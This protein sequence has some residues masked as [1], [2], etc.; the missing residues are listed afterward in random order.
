MFRRKTKKI[1]VLCILI[2]SV[3]INF[4]CATIKKPANPVDPYETM[5]RKMFKFNSIFDNII[6][7]PIAVTYQTIIPRPL[8][9]GIS[10]FFS[11]LNE[12]TT[13]SNDFLQGNIKNMFA[14]SW[15]L[16]FNSTIGIGGLFD[17]ATSLGLPQRKN[18]FGLTLAKWGVRNSPYIVSPFFGPLTARD[19]FGAL[20]DYNLLSPWPYIEPQTFRYSL[21]GTYFINK[22]AK[23]LAADKFIQ[24]AFDPYIFVR[25]AYL[26]YRQ[27]QIDNMLGKTTEE[28]PKTYLS[29]EIDKTQSKTLE[30]KPLVM[31]LD[32]EKPCVPPPMTEAEGKIL[33]AK[34]HLTRHT[35]P[36]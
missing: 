6:F 25:N 16:L 30:A 28:L 5:N 35:K 33:V 4:G 20:V 3:C 29:S 32:L 24:E 12:V 19:G 7:R 22:R 23:I 34:P 31:E 17:V 26:Q 36:P 10:N 8:Q 14:N 13:I 15:R 11:N 2:L 9:S 27:Q 1:I 18:D 21:Y